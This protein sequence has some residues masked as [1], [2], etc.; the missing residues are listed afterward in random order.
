[1]GS[2]GRAQLDLVLCLSVE[3]CPEMRALRLASEAEF[4]WSAEM[5]G[6]RQVAFFRRPEKR[7]LLELYL[8]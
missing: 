4:V 2:L 6:L 5:A 7:L 3:L 1:L 8:V